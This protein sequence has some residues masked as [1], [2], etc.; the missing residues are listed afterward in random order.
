[1]IPR[2]IDP[3][4]V[5]AAVMPPL[6]NVISVRCINPGGS[7]SISELTPVSQAPPSPLSLRSV[8]TTDLRLSS[9]LTTKVSLR[10]PWR[11]KTTGPPMVR[12]WSDDDTLTPWSEGI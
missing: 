5:M 4:S 2:A 8:C 9:G 11:N 6:P 1:M 3:H 7:D 12:P 10:L